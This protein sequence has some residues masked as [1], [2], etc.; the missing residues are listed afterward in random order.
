MGAVMTGMAAH[1]GVLPVGGTFF[2]FS[3]YM[4]GAVRVAALSDDPRH[5]LVDP[6]LGRPGPGRAH[7]PAHRA[8]GGPAGHAQPAGHPARPTPTRRRQAWRIAVDS[9]GP[10]ALILSR[11]DAAGAG[12]DGRAGRHGVP[13]GRLRAAGRGGRRPGHRPD[14]APAARSSCAWPP[15]TCWGERG[16]ARVVSFPCW[17]LFED[18]ARRVPLEVLPDGVARL[19]VEAAA[20]FG[21]ERY[22]DASV[23]IDHF[24]ASAPGRRGPGGV[25]VHGRERGR[26]GSGPCSHAEPADNGVTRTNPARPEET[27]DQLHD[28]YDQQG[29][30]ARGS[31]TCAATGSQDGKLAGLVT[32]A[33]GG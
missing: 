6:R 22:A 32:R 16:A 33:S 26:A 4:R 7:P 14:R 27:H 11:Q 25:R 12:R 13:R 10:T 19:A 5:L 2:V 15:P 1:G 29:A 30:R 20:S 17:E 21:W 18:A 23:C 8:A 28:L 9:D 31:T 3:D 24:G